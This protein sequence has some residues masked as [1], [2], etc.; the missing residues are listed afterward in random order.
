VA[1]RDALIRD[2]LWDLLEVESLTKT[3]RISAS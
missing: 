3:S 1:D 2:F